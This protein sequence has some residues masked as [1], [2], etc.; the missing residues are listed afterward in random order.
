MAILGFS[1]C[2]PSGF[3]ILLPTVRWLVSSLSCSCWSSEFVSKYLPGPGTLLSTPR[4][5]N[6]LY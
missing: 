4:S 3:L 1:F 2:F 5:W 6:R